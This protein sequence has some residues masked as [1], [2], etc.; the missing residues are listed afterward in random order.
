VTPR[1]SGPFG[2]ERR[3]SAATSQQTKAFEKLKKDWQTSFG[4]CVT[5]EEGKRAEICEG[6]RI[7]INGDF[8][9][10]EMPLELFRCPFGSNV[11]VTQRLKS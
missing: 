4:W 8:E 5:T 2:D 11:D 6:D 7:Q 9:G 1:P 3:G 10:T